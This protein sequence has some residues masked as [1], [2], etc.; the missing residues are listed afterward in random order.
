MEQTVPDHQCCPSPS[1]TVG[2]TTTA[3]LP[4]RGLYER[5]AELPLVNSTIDHLSRVY[6]HSEA[7]PYRL[8]RLGAST[9]RFMGTTLEPTLRSLDSYAGRQLARLTSGWQLTAEMRSKLESTVESLWRAEAYIGDLLGGLRRRAAELHIRE[10]AAELEPE[11]HGYEESTD[12]GEPKDVY[13]H[14]LGEAVSREIVTTLRAVIDIVNRDGTL[15]P[16]PGQTA[17]RSFLMGLPTRFAGILSTYGS[18]AR[19]VLI[20]DEALVWIKSLAGIVNAYLLHQHHHRAGGPSGVVPDAKEG[21]ESPETLIR[22]CPRGAPMQKDF[23]LLS[24]SV[25]VMAPSHAQPDI[26]TCQP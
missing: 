11:I 7:S 19:V 15:L 26:S 4:E 13:L 2:T 18:P 12:L 8:L 14:D 5:V 20:A 23:S 21:G 17:L 1:P 25:P 24:G 3:P 6:A 16:L 9:V 22:R 10:Q